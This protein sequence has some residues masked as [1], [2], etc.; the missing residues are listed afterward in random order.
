MKTLKELFKESKKEVSYSF[1]LKV[2]KQPLDYEKITRDK[3][4]EQIMDAYYD[5]PEIILRMCSLE[6]LNILKRLLEKNILKEE[7]GYIESVLFHNL[8]SNYLAFESD[9]E[10]YLP[11]DLINPIKMAF[12]IFNEEEYSPK[13]FLD[14]VILGLIRIYNVVS[15]SDFIKYLENYNIYYDEAIFKDT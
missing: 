11:K 10:Y 4:Y 5:D 1:Y 8:K 2:V 13:D 14:C 3:I 9:K 7:S 6:E 12:N 15:L